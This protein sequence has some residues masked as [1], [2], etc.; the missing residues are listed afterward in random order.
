MIPPKPFPTC[1]RNLFKVL[2][3]SAV[4]IPGPARPD[5]LPFFVRTSLREISNKKRRNGFSWIPTYFPVFYCRGEHFPGDAI[6]T[7]VLLI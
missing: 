7:L 6:N 2:L 1:G 4:S 5:F 3:V